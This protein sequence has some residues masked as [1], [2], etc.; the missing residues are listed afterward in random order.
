MS[1]NLARLISNKIIALRAI[2]F[3]FLKIDIKGE[4]YEKGHY[5]SVI[6]SQH[7]I[8]KKNSDN[9][10]NYQNLDGIS[11]DLEEQISVLDQ[12]KHIA[13]E[14]GLFSQFEMKR[15]DIENDTF[16]YD[17]APLLS[18]FLRLTKPSRII[19]VGSGNSSALMLD[20]N[21]KF[22][23]R[24]INFIFIDQNCSNLRSNLLADDSG[25]ISIIEKPIQ[26]VDLSIF[27]SLECNDLLFIDSSHVAK[28]GSDIN[29]I[30]FK[31]LPILKPGVFIH[32]H[33]IRFPFEYPK[34][35]A[36]RKIY[37]NEAYFLRAFLQYNQ[38]FKIFFWL[39][40]LLNTDDPQIIAR[41]KFLPL[42]KWDAKFNNSQLNFKQAGGSIYLIKNE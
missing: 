35:L 21:D 41:S 28:I 26:E 15:F 5:Y 30:F 16:S 23:K 7:D 38:K 9:A 33:D 8:L 32:F 11:I 24:S 25:R 36:K 18:Y 2:L 17:D 12:F 10:Y 6:P 34:G 27:E 31:I 29:H 19:E 3:R 4:L 39:N 13:D 14:F 37:W 1:H 42:D 20:I 22:F 40:Y